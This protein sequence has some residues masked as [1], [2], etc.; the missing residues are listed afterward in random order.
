M[1]RGRPSGGRLGV[2]L[3][4]SAKLALTGWSVGWAVGHPAA[5]GAAAF[6]T[7][8][9]LAE[10]FARELLLAEVDGAWGQ[11]QT[12]VAE[13]VTR[14]L[15]QRMPRPS[16]RFVWAGAASAFATGVGGWRSHRTRWLVDP[17]PSGL[18]GLATGRLRWRRSWLLTTLTGSI[19]RWGTGRACDV[20]ACACSRGHAAGAL[21]PV[22]AVL[23]LEHGDASPS[24]MVMLWRVC[25]LSSAAARLWTS[26]LGLWSVGRWCGR[27]L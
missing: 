14:G 12:A 23:G 8:G 19:R 17:R 5:V 18:L 13:S 6:A 21:L 22:V 24:G 26:A 27:P 25:V 2:E 20:G 9:P 3:R 15:G 7:V 4:P 11:A 16:A 1:R 10:R